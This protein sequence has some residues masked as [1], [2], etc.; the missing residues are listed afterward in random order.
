L[1]LGAKYQPWWQTVIGISMQQ[2]G[3]FPL[4]MS[5]FFD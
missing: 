4:F 3:A 5:T 2:L 1:S